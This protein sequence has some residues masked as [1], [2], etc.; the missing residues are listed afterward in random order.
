MKTVVENNLENYQNIIANKFVLPT[1]ELRRMFITYHRERYPIFEIRLKLNKKNK[2]DSKKTK[3]ES[4]AD[5]DASPS[6]TLIADKQIQSKSK[7]DGNTSDNANTSTN[8]NNNNNSNVSNNDK[9][10]PADNKPRKD[11][12]SIEWWTYALFCWP[13]RQILTPLLRYRMHRVSWLGSTSESLDS[14]TNSR[15]SKIFD[16]NQPDVKIC[17]NGRHFHAG[18]ILLFVS[19]LIVF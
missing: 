8:F 14:Q 7:S 3:K 5:N 2:D 11:K 12:S 17:S 15:T 4:T 10:G 19:I 13:A 1:V 9:H 16:L 18:F 6:K